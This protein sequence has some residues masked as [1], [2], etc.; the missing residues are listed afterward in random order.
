[1]RADGATFAEIAAAYGIRPGAAH[2]RV[3]A[4]YE[5]W[6]ALPATMLHDQLADQYDAL[7]AAE[8]FAATA[9]VP[10]LRAARAVLRVTKRRARL[11]DLYPGDGK[12]RRRRLGRGIPADTTDYDAIEREENTSLTGEGQLAADLAE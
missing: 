7:V 8:W 11:L 6:I 1:M 9:D 4:D 5:A 12:D 10:D 2:K 3:D